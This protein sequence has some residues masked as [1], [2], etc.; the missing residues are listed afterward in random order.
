MTQI[1]HGSPKPTGAITIPTWTSLDFWKQMI[2]AGSGELPPQE[3]PPIRLPK[4]RY[5]RLE[6]TDYTLEYE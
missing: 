6:C 1:S 3:H 5:A 4:G 2:D